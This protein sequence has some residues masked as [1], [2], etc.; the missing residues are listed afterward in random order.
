MW[1][2]IEAGLYR[3]RKTREPADVIRVGPRK[4]EANYR[5]NGTRDQRFFKTAREAKLHIE[6]TCR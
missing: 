2:R 3:Y 6:L 1:E 4:W 5:H